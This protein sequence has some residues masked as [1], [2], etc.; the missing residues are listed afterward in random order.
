M[1]LR[2]VSVVLLH[3]V[4]VKVSLQNEIRKYIVAQ[5]NFLHVQKFMRMLLLPVL[6]PSYGFKKDDPDISIVPNVNSRYTDSSSRYNSR[7][8]DCYMEV[9]VP[10]LSSLFNRMI[11]INMVHLH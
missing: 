6:H 2:T 11:D 4:P 7:Y 8:T 9:G 10:Q 1:L 5:L 3:I